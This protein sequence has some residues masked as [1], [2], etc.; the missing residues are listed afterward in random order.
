MLEVERINGETGEIVIFCEFTHDETYAMAKFVMDCLCVPWIDTYQEFDDL[1]RNIFRR[2]A[3]GKLITRME[4]CILADKYERYYKY[5]LPLFPKM[6]DGGRIVCPPHIHGDEATEWLIKTRTEIWHEVWELH[7]KIR[8]TGGYWKFPG[9][10]A[11]AVFLAKQHERENK[12]WNEVDVRQAEYGCA[13]RAAIIAVSD[14][15]QRAEFENQL[16]DPTLV[17]PT[18][19]DP[20]LVDESII[21]HPTSNT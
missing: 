11:D 5:G 17:D 18:L 6:R 3:Q 13:R 20:T 21:N 14:Y 4:A 7:K 19:V 15:I 12:F 8:G 2:S 10:E 1:L 9:A 16:P